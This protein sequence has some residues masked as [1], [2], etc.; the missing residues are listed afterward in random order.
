MAAGE[1]QL[2]HGHTPERDVPGGDPDERARVA[3]SAVLH[4]TLLV[5]VRRPNGVLD[6][7]TIH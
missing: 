6:R 7:S 1:N 5:D 2:L 4:R 3:D